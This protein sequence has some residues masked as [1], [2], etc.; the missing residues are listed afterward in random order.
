MKEAKDEVYK[1]KNRW[2]A[3][4][5]ILLFIQI[6]VGIIVSLKVFF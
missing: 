2:T 3:T 6:I 5:A 4:I 1:Q